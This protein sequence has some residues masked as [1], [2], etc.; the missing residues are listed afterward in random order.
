MLAVQKKVAGPLSAKASVASLFREGKPNAF[1]LAY[2]LLKK[3]N[4]HEQ[5]MLWHLAHVLPDSALPLLVNNIRSM[6]ACDDLR[7][8]AP[9]ISRS[10]GNRTVLS[11]INNFLTKARGR[12]ERE[13]KRLQKK[14]GG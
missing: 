13:L 14:Y 10:S 11:I 6:Y 5:D 1:L 12:N 2:T 8:I 9:K 3:P 4:R 7:V